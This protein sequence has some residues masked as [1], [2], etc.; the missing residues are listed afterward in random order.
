MTV[1]VLGTYLLAKNA[2]GKWIVI[3]TAKIS[4][5][6]WHSLSLLEQLPPPPPHILKLVLQPLELQVKV[7]MAGSLSVLAIQ[8]NS[9]TL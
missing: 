2:N 6:E 4:I 7:E 3:N 8:L 5:A 9:Q 1:R